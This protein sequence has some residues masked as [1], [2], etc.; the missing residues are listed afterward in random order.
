MRTFAEGTYTPNDWRQSGLDLDGREGVLERLKWS[1]MALSQDAE[2]QNGLF[3]DFVVVADELAL[4]WDEALN[5]L[6]DPDLRINDDQKS[7]IEKLD[8]MILAIS[9]LENIKFW[10]DDALEVFQEW[11]DIRLAASEVLKSFGW[12]IAAPPP[13]FDIYISGHKGM[14]D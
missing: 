13:S 5:E 8:A 1:A 9:G 3:P 14:V 11:E 10:D 2:T 4:N 7:K 12:P 6:N